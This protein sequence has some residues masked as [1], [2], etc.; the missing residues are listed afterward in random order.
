MDDVSESRGGN[1]LDEVVRRAVALGVGSVIAGT[2]AGGIGGRIAMRISAATAPSAVQGAATEGGNTVGV[3]SAEGTIAL[4]IFAGV[5]SGLAGAGTLVVTDPWLRGPR[6]VRALAL[7]VLA[8]SIA[9]VLAIEADNF[10][11][12]IMQHPLL[13]VVML[14]ALF[15]L[16]GYLALWFGDRLETRWRRH[17]AS[18]LLIVV[19]AVGGFASVGMTLS[20]Y[21]WDDS[22]ADPPPRLVLVGLAVISAATMAHWVQ[23]AR[24]GDQPPVLL[25]AVVVGAAL[26][27]VPG[28]VYMTDQ[29][30]RI[31]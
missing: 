29:I 7:G 19:A 26:V 17:R 11:F 31:L 5:A 3:V 24:G 18:L 10:D 1:A 4:V 30:S 16:Y 9:G 22:L 2:L 27:V 8:F 12:R 21:L 14:A 20:L 6:W 13:D 15:P 23:R 28:T 25:G